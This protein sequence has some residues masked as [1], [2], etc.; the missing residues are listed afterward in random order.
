MEIRVSV[1]HKRASGIIAPLIY[2][3]FTGKNMIYGT[4]SKI[5]VTLHL[6]LCPL[7][8]SLS[9]VASPFRLVEGVRR[10][11]IAPGRF[12]YEIRYS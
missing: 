7:A 5:F 3:T 12:L 8:G 9:P 11:F 4:L 1:S 10:Y 6:C 2:S